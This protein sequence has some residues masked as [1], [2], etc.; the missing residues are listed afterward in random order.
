L[1]EF[2]YLVFFA[3]TGFVVITVFLV[4]TG[5]TGL[6]VFAAATGFLTAA[7]AG[8][9]TIMVDAETSATER[10][11]DVSVLFIVCAFQEPRKVIA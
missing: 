1:G 8:D 11:A 6:V 4:V 3:G 2:I 10:I 9:A 7:F 5:F